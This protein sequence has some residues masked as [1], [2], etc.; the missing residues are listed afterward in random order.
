MVTEYNVLSS[1]ITSALEQYVP[2][3]QYNCSCHKS[4]LNLDLAPFKDG[5][6]KEQ[7]DIA[8]S[9]GTKYQV[10]WKVFDSKK[11]YQLVIHF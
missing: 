11:V 2:C 1:K 10:S 6:T 4:V 3:K 8:Q 9:K 7:F 5:V